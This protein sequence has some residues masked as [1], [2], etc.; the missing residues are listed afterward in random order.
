MPERVE[1][2]L[3][4]PPFFKVFLKF[5]TCFVDQVKKLGKNSDENREKLLA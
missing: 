1:F 3:M 5:I 2:R 4:A